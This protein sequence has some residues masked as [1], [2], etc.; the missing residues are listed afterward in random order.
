MVK[1]VIK[2]QL[3]SIDSDR[4]PIGFIIGGIRGGVDATSCL[5]IC[6]YMKLMTRETAGTQLEVTLEIDS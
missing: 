4:Q 2:E 6:T 5:H 3:K 1:L